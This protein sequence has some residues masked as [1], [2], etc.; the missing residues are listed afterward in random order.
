M[1]I[2][3]L[4]KRHP[5]LE[6]ALV[7]AVATS[8]GPVFSYKGIVCLIVV[9]TLKLC[10]P[11]P[12]RRV[13]ARLASAF[14]SALVR[15]GVAA[16]TC[17]ERDP[18]VFDVGFGV[19]RGNFAISHRGVTFRTSHRGVRTRQRVLRSCMIK[20]GSRLPAFGGMASRAVGAKLST[21][22]IL[23]AT[24]ARAGESQVGAIQVFYLNPGLARR[25]NLPR[26]MTFFTPQHRVF[27]GKRKTRLA[28]IHG[29]PAG[30]PMNKREVHSVVV[31]VAPR[32]I[33][34][35]YRLSDPDCVHT[36]ILNETIADFGMAI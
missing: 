3:A 5:R 4:R 24:R 34:T 15:I 1:A 28:V 16:D 19:S 32:T 6:I 27:P 17:G 9:E 35:R 29:L 20:A 13:M 7:V 12:V 31:G 21:V 18:C 10:Y 33:L 26:I 2:R 14:E 25:Q 8:Y 30:L 11:L 23:M 36:A 22:L